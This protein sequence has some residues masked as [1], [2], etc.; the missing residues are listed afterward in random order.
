MRGTLPSSLAS[1]TRLTRISFTNNS[2][3]SGVLPE[4]LSSLTGLKYLMA[5]QTALSGTIM[6]QLQEFASLF[7]FKLAETQISGSI[8][9][10]FG[11]LPNLGGAILWNMRLSGSLPATISLLTAYSDALAGPELTLDE[12]A[13]SGTLPDC[14]GFTCLS[15][16]SVQ[17]NW[18]ISGT[19]PSRLSM[20]SR[21]GSLR[22]S[23][24]RMSGTMVD[25]PQFY[26]RHL[27]VDANR[28]SG[29]LC[30]ECFGSGLMAIDL[31]FNEFSGTLS[32]TLWANFTF[33]HVI[34]LN[35]LRLS[36]TLPASLGKAGKCDQ[37]WMMCNGIIHLGFNANSLSGA[38][39]R[40]RTQN[41]SLLL[42]VS[43]SNC[44]YF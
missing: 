10:G 41:H 22:T 16:L 24:N 9:Q 32:Q 12:N 13:F 21:L 19:L 43:Q 3:L 29:T 28:M 35:G 11:L 33:L 38:D 27:K 30:L 25:L 1:L 44:P 7:T 14:N 39:S 17:K 34:A 2:F 8:P 26:M 6:P 42:T 40:T 5:D 37:W 20:I 36:S 23:H 18:K 15:Q 31:S 4:A